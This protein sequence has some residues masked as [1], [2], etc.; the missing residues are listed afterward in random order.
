MRD[1]GL[2]EDRSTEIKV[3]A[4][5]LFATVALIVGLFWITDTDLTP[6]GI[7]V[8]GVTEDAGQVTSGA[9]VFL[10]GV[11]V[12]S[13]ESVELRQDRVLIG[14]RVDPG[15]TLPADTR[16]VIHPPGF[17]GGQRVDLLPGQADDRLREGDTLSLAGAPGLQEV[18]G[19]LGSDASEVMERARRVLS[20]E[21][22][23]D[24][25]RSSA[26]LAESVRDVH[27]LVESQ[28]QDIDALMTGMRR[29]SENLAGA[30]SGPELERT[31]ARLDSLSGRLNRAGEGLDASSRSLA[32]ILEKV[33]GGEGSL[34]RMV[35]DD[36]LYEEAAAALSN[37]RIATEEIGLLSRD[38]RDQPDR[39]LR[40]LRFSVF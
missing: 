18:A 13:V 3:G 6:S 9:R 12:G 8:Y 39:Y 22:V 19:E 2:R 30:T 21:T 36:G 26:L 40:E 11:D 4:V 25:R 17:L 28:R 23:S 27:E 33:D 16:G 20:E 5:V 32:S 24:V 10:L 7:H 34:G 15:R 35:N 37:L 14:L 38:I 29:T 31:L 1:P